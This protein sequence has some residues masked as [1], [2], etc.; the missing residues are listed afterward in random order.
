MSVYAFIVISRG[1]P[2]GFGICRLPFWHK[3][4]TENMLQLFDLRPQYGEL[5][6]MADSSGKVS[7]YE[8][9]RI[10]KCRMESELGMERLGKQIGRSSK[11]IFTHIHSHNNMIHAVGKCQKCE[12]VGSKLCDQLC[13]V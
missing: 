11:T 10:I 1:G 12:R 9:V 5:P 6:F 3:M 13:D 8:H 4:E 2:L 7:D